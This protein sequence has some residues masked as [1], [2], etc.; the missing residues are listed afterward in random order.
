MR[1]E[2]ILPLL[3]RSKFGR[4]L[5]DDQIREL[6]GI[7]ICERLPAGTEV[8]QEGS[9]AEALWVI[10][11]GSVDIRL[12]LSQRPAAAIQTLNPPE[13]LG[14]SALVGDGLMSATAVTATPATLLRLPADALKDLCI[15]D[16]TL[17]YAVMGT[18]AA[19]LTCRLAAARRQVAAQMLP[20]G[21]PPGRPGTEHASAACELAR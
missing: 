2:M 9:R 10:C 17:G 7:A 19:T 15:A 20:P 16:H 5:R 6:A 3:R 13:L 11:E 4:L 8:F 1:D 14:W 12:N 18:I 21:S